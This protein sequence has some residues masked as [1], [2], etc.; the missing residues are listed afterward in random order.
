[1]SSGAAWRESAPLLAGLSAE[2]LRGLH[3]NLT[4]GRPVSPDL[5]RL[6]PQ[7]AGLL[8]LLLLAGVRALP[9]QAIAVEWRAQ[10]DAF[11]D[12]VGRAPDFID[13][14][15]HVHHLPGV[16]E[17][18]LSRLRPGVA[19]R[20]TGRPQGPGFAFKR[21]VIAATGGRRLSALLE[22]QGR[23]HN[24]V[25]VGVYDFRRPDYRAL[26]R[27]WLRFLPLHGAL[28]F[29]HPGDG[30]DA[31][32]TARRREAKYLGSAHFLE[33]LASEGV[34]LGPAWPQSSSAG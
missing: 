3:F 4:A 11:V 32:G 22:C 24:D 29:C 12:A 5:R 16:R 28:L 13:G 7:G 17:L 14:H 27:G 15:Q 1:L 30:L 23:A 8:Q 21:A 31:M 34:S 6:W 2:V 25:L 33:D 19:V 10:W 18:I 26:V 9:L 20:S